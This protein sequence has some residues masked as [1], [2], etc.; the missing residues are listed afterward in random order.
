MAAILRDDSGTTAAG[1]SPLA[2]GLSNRVM[3]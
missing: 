1:L 3:C 2:G